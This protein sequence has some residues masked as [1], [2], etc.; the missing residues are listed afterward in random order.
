[1]LYPEELPPNYEGHRGGIQPGDVGYYS[2]KRFVR[3]A[4]ILPELIHEGI[5]KGNQ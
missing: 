5:V 2:S 3:V 1:M 4:N